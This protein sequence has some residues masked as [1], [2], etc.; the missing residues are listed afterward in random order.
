MSLHGR[1]HNL[2]RHVV[3]TV[4]GLLLFYSHSFHG[5]CIVRRDQHKLSRYISEMVNIFGR[6]LCS[7]LHIC[8]HIWAHWEPCLH[9]LNM[10][11]VHTC[12]LKYSVIKP[13]WSQINFS[14]KAVNFLIIISYVSLHHTVASCVQYCDIMCTIL[15]HHVYNTVASCVQYCDIM[16]T[17]L[18]YIYHVILCYPLTPLFLTQTGCCTAC[19]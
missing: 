4:S 6:A 11:N 17:I 14:S 3:G 5:G 15:W 2:Y 19:T 1:I 13:N 12:S 10:V 18:W 8:N 9:I 16:W 7:C